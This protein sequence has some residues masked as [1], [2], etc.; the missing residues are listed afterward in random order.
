MGGKLVQNVQKRRRREIW[1]DGWDGAIIGRTL[2]Q[3]GVWE[4]TWRERTKTT[5]PS[6]PT[7][8]LCAVLVINLNLRLIVY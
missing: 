1:V 4:N 2:G 8:Y 3:T 5:S 6:V 7:R